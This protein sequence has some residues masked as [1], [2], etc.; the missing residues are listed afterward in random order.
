MSERKNGETPEKE[1]TQRSETESICMFCFATVRSR[2]P[3][4]LRLAQDVHS[5][6][7]P[8]RFWEPAEQR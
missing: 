4:H 2:I 5:Q 8:A 3:E 1:F 6:V 7:C